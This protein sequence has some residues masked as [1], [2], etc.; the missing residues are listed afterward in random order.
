L[1]VCQDDFSVKIEKQGVFQRAVDAFY[2]LGQSSLFSSDD[3]D[4]IGYIVDALGG[5]TISEKIEKMKYSESPRVKLSHLIAIYRKLRKIV[6]PV[7]VSNPI[8]LGYVILF[9][10]S[11]IACMH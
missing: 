6:G 1:K 2:F 11:S 4:G 5:G 7:S 3:D 10:M 9:I 8:L